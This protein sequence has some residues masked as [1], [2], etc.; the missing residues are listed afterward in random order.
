MATITL[1]RMVSVTV[2]LG[3]LKTSLEGKWDEFWYSGL[4]PAVLMGASQS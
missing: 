4:L 1:D 2:G 3:G